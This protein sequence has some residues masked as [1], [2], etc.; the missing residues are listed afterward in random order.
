M[1][2]INVYVGQ[3]FSYSFPQILT[4]VYTTMI[5]KYISYLYATVELL[6]FQIIQHNHRL[7]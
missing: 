6:Y 5:H 3:M 7:G 4:L 2:I 1:F